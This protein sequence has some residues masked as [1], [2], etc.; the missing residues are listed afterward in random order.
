M[1][2]R[3]VDRRAPLLDA[4]QLNPRIV[5]EHTD[6]GH[7][8]VLNQAHH[9]AHA[10]RQRADVRLDADAH[11]VLRRVLRHL[12]DAGHRFRPDVVEPHAR[13][14]VGL[15]SAVYADERTMQQ[16]RDLNNALKIADRIR[17]ILR[18][19]E[20]LIVGGQA[21]KL[22]PSGLSRF[23]DPQSLVVGDRLGINL[24]ARLIALALAMIDAHLYAVIADLRKAVDHLINVL[25]RRAHRMAGKFDSVVHAICS[26]PVFKIQGGY[27]GKTS[28]ITANLH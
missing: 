8:D 23:I 7:V 10:H 24:T 11:A 4:G 25:V 6:I 3:R 27:G 28:P 12:A 22:Q 2:R 21:G 18:E 16:R 1:P 13:Q 17:P 20:I 14:L 9:I 26:F 19:N 15:L 5:E